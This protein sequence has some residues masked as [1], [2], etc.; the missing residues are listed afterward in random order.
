[1]ELWGMLE[2]NGT[3]VSGL[4]HYI[5]PPSGSTLSDI[6]IAV[7]SGV[8]VPANT[9]IWITYTIFLTLA[10]VMF[11]VFWVST[12][13]MDSKSVSEQIQKVGLGIPGFRRDPRIIEKVLDRYIPYLAVL[14]GASVGILAA[15]ADFTGALGTGTGI[16]LTVMIIHNL[17]EDVVSKHME[18]MHP[19]LQ[20]FM[21]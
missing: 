3:P 2:G 1:M 8:S 19:A 21:R 13:G 14:G 4:L 9:Y 6:I 18:D 16:L 12:S 10:S 20:K 15:F 5:T 7:G 11:A 17:Y